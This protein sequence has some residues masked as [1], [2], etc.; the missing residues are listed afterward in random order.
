MRRRWGDARVVQFGGRREFGAT[1]W[2]GG[3]PA[4]KGVGHLFREGR[5]KKKTKD[6]A[7]SVKYLKPLLGYVFHL[8]RDMCIII[9]M[10]S[11]PNVAAWTQR[12]MEVS[13]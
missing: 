6:D 2:T 11:Y 3:F 10:I 9:L 12:K 1:F 5:G 7:S 4:C 13:V 8:G